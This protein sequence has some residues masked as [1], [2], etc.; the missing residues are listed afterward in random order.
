MLRGN[1]CVAE[2]AGD[3]LHLN[4]TN[5]PQLMS[6]K[7]PFKTVLWDKTC[8]C[9]MWGAGGFAGVWYHPNS[10]IIQGRLAVV[11]LSQHSQRWWC[12]GNVSSQTDRSKTNPQEHLP[13]VYTHT[14]FSVSILFLWDDGLML[15]LRP[16]RY[17]FS[18]LAIWEPHQKMLSPYAPESEH[19][20][21]KSWYLLIPSFCFFFFFF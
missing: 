21:I 20:E 9:G 3:V 4:Y 2:G 14:H 13:P 16:Q 11:L 19:L 7:K 18:L 10:W 12:S 5:L 15:A 1:L 8:T 17:L 6:I